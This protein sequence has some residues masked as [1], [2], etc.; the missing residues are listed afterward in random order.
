MYNEVKAHR[1]D[2]AEIKSTNISKAIIQRSKTL[3]KSEHR[4][5]LRRRRGHSVG[6]KNKPLPPI[7]HQKIETEFSQMPAQEYKQGIV[8][9]KCVMEA[10]DKKAKNRQWQLCYLISSETE[11]M[12]YRPILKSDSKG[13]RRKS[14]IFWHQSVCP[15]F[16]LQ[17]IV[18]SETDEWQPDPNQP[19]LAAIPLNHCYATSLLPPGWN[20]QRP[21]VF[22]LE[23]ADGGL[24]MFETTDLYAVQAWVEA[25]NHAA[26]LISKSPMQGA[27]CNIDYGWDCDKST[28]MNHI[29]VWHPPTPCMIQSTLS[30]NEQYK[31]LKSQI[32]ELAQQLDQ[33]RLLKPIIDKKVN[34]GRSSK[35]QMCIS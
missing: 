32:R 7:P 6:T 27:V 33:H 26:A 11:L 9:R 2:Q 15:S 14:M 35:V 18:N 10:A 31:E 1:I 17:D 34:R 25:V 5:V 8:M 24:W 3:P 12:M 21:Y 20:G 23:T 4:K 22:R 19:P 28:M 30:L 16:S 13:M 29:A